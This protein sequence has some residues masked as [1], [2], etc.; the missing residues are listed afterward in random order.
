MV[1][2]LTN[3]AAMISK[4]GVSSLKLLLIGRLCLL[5]MCMFYS[6]E[7]NCVWLR[8]DCV[9]LNRLDHAGESL[10]SRHEI[11][12]LPRAVKS[13]SHTFSYLKGRPFRPSGVVNLAPWLPDK[14]GARITIPHPLLTWKPLSP[15]Y[16]KQAQPSLASAPKSS[17]I[18]KRVL[19]KVFCTEAKNQKWLCS[20]L[21]K[22]AVAAELCA[23]SHWISF[24]AAHDVHI[25]TVLA[26]NE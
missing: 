22:V 7:T 24:K 14:S 20:Y 6:H 8:L 23:S 26:I 15:C 5:L 12:G 19:G 18:K 10:E 16:T 1:W 13:L 11:Y 17:R 2:K 25:N 21:M 3:T 4:K 9:P